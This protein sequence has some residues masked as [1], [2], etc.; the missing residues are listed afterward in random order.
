MIKFHLELYLYNDW[1]ISII[2]Q[3]KRYLDI[4]DR[5]RFK[6]SNYYYDKNKRK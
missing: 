2:A 1:N 4:C 5:E 3:L 6:K